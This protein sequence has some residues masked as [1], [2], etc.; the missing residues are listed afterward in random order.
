MPNQV[1]NATKKER[2]REL[3]KID[4]VLQK[5]YYSK[6]KG[7]E[8][9]V[10]IEEYKNGVSIGHTENFIKVEIKGKLEENTNY[11]VKIMKAYSDYVIGKV[12]K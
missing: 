9:E 10:L 5:E 6:F 8:V 4:E 12:I 7:E 3:I 11:K 1:D 2:A